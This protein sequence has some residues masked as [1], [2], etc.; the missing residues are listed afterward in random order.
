V[1]L[2]WT[3]Q[4]P[5]VVAKYLIKP[6]EEIAAHGVV[7][8]LK[9]SCSHP[10]LSDRI[11][12]TCGKTIDAGDYKATVH[13]TPGLRTLASVA[14]QTAD[15]HVQQ[16]ISQRKLICVFDLDQTLIFCQEAANLPYLQ[17]LAGRCP[18]VHSLSVPGN[19]NSMVLV[20]RPGLSA[21]LAAA[22]ELFECHLYTLGSRPY[23][24]AV[25]KIID[26]D[27][28]V[29]GNR[30]LTITESLSKEHK[31]VHLRHLFSSGACALRHKTRVLLMLHVMAQIC[32]SLS[33]STT[34]HGHGIG[35]RVSWRFSRLF[36]KSRRPTRTECF[37]RVD[38]GGQPW[39]GA[40]TA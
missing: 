35:R 20:V 23:A 28:R 40:S 10:R 29:F 26:P 1:P 22:A 18:Q 15:D 4:T 17:P 8:Q 25:L 24:E 36:P 3:K 38:G 16:L 21:A 33:S 19:P 2:R 12:T 34:T 13:A 32:G 39:T 14:Q 6:G 11:C 30:V 5:G 7:V 27:R 31:H 9:I 37:S